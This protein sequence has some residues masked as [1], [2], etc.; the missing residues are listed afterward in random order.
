MDRDVISC[1]TCGL[2]QYRTRRG[3]CRRCLH[4]LPPK[5]DLLVPPAQPQELPDDDQQFSE[6]WPN[7]GS[8]ENIGQRIRQLRESCG[9]TRS[10][11]QMR[12]HVS[13]SWLSRIEMGKKTP[14]LGTLEKISEVL[15]VG[16]NRF[17]LS[18]SSSATVLDDPFILNLWPFLRQLDHDQWQSIAKRIAAIDAHVLTSN[19]QSSSLAQPQRRNGGSP[20]GPIQS[21]AASQR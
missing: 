1:K 8:V 19:R 4:V 2:V 16:L 17:F 20:H 5:V 12:S 9:L 11:L 6:Q 3:N 14:S 18:Q 21:L 7:L 15:G 13:R 10:Q